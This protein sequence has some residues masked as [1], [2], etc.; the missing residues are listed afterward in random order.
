M[1]AEG[2][3][4]KLVRFFLDAVIIAGFIA[5][6]LY[7]EFMLPVMYKPLLS[8]VILISMLFAVVLYTY[9]FLFRREKRLIVSAAVFLIAFLV[10]LYNG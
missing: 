7:D 1:G 9:Q 6:F 4:E 10:M 8:F 2:L 3:K 5:Y